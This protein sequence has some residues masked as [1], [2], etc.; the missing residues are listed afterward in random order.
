MPQIIS[1][2][3]GFTGFSRRQASQGFVEPGE[4]QVQIPNSPAPTP[5]PPD[6]HTLAAGK[7]KGEWVA[8][9]LTPKGEELEA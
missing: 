3:S 1:E 8:W 4:G 5:N 7:W 9:V 2:W 6:T